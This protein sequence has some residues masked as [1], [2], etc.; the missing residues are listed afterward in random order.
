MDL[1]GRLIGSIASLSILIIVAALLRRSGLL[2]REA[3]GMFSWLVTHVTL[4]ALIVSSL[5]GSTL[6][7]RELDLAASMFA[8][9]MGCLLVALLAAAALRLDRRR[10]GS[11]LLVSTFGSSALL[12]YALV[13]QVF[14]GSDSALSD[15]VIISETGVAP[16]LFVLGVWIAVSFGD[17][18]GGNGPGKRASLVFL[19]SPVFIALLLGILLSKLGMPSGGPVTAVMDLLATAGKANTFLV[20]ITVGLLLDWSGMKRMFLTALTSS[21]I[22]LILQPLIAMSAVA[23]FGIT[24][25]P[26]SVLL[27]QTAMPAATLSVVFA[28]QYGCDSESASFMLLVSTILS[29]LTI[30]VLFALLT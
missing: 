24:G 8:G 9:E 30:P 22:K 25:T 3:A 20:A 27:L 18:H 10:K 5:A 23:L 6:A 13:S 26:R 17:R 1:T 21:S 28:H 11:F 15:A 29:A 7:L 2:K 14:P 19:R 4:P 16:T 12:G